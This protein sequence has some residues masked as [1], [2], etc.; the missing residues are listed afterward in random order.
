M[1]DNRSNS[2]DS[3]MFGPIPEGDVVGRA[4]LRVWPIGDLGRL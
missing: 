3:R 4:F 1:G 2:K